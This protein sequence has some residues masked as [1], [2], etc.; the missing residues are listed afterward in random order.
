ML[1]KLV[2]KFLYYPTVLHQDVPV[3]SYAQG[4]SEVFLNAADGNRI[5]AL[6]WAP[7]PGRPTI[8]FFHGN[9]QSVFEWALIHEDFREIDAGLLLV[10]YPGYGKSSGY[11]HETGLYHAGQAAYDWLV[12]DRKL[13]PK[14]MIVFG[15]SL[16]G[17][18]AT[19]IAADNSVGFLILE[20][21][22]TSIPSVAR[23]LL[24][25]VPRDASF[26]KE[27]YDSISRLPQI[28]VPVLV[29]HGTKDE[30]IELE[31]G[32]KLFAAAN[33]PKELFLVESAGHNDV[34]MV[35]GHQYGETI[36]RWIDK[37][38]TP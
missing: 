11:P 18:V 10:D 33:E 6:Y 30:L 12:N 2:Q 8:L 7:K 22:F 16:G 28:H 32:K 34:S 37:Q 13:D 14:S 21:T 26:K 38:I 35:A 23:K 29:I 1:E 20:S 25:I 5:H 19:K 17:G 3:P 24:P 27:R 4:A 31:E 36:R 15:K 9:A